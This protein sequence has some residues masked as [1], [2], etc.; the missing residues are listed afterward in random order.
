MQA[1]IARF[2]VRER[3]PPYTGSRNI[4]PKKVSLEGPVPEFKNG[5]QLRDYQARPA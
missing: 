5:R 2:E 4:K 1:E 3:A